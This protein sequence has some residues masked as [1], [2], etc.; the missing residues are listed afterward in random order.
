AAS[1][2][3]RAC[4]RVSESGAVV[5]SSWDLSLPD[6]VADSTAAACM[7]TSRKRSLDENARPPGEKFVRHR[8]LRLLLPLSMTLSG[9]GRRVPE[10]VVT[11]IDIQAKEILRMREE[12]NRILVHHTGQ[13]ME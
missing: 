4:A 9:T 10:A 11:D 7:Y 3:R 5:G 2:P 1:R 6:H 8:G 13:S 12:L